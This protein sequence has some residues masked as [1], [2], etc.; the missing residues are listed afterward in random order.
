MDIKKLIESYCPVNLQEE[1][2]KR[3]ILGI[4]EADADCFSRDN[5]KCHFTVSSWIV[6]REC[7]KVLFCYHKIYDS[8]SWVGGHADGD[9]NLLSVAVKEAREETGIEPVEW[10]E[11]ILSLEILP[12]AG[13]IKKGCYVSS[14]IHL[15]VT[16][17]LYADE[18]APLKINPDENTGLKWIA[19]AD[20]P[21]M[22][23]EKW[24]V[25]T[26]YSK[27]TDKLSK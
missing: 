18:D 19:F 27:I 25:D 8:W 17:L 6:N 12:V 13:H 20:I 11:E 21:S 14:H 3:E 16:F 5:E 1:K 9:K 15:N 10:C 7:T 4:L 24:M 22:S 26:I 2:D 23:T